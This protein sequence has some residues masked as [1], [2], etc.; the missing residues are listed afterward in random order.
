MADLV[1]KIRD[2]AF[3]AFGVAIG[4]A[5]NLGVPQQ[6]LVVLAFGL[7]GCAIIYF[8]IKDSDSGLQTLLLS[9]GAIAILTSKFLSAV[10]TLVFLIMGILLMAAMFVL[11]V[12]GIRRTATKR[13]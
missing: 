13:R 11:G 6:N 8:C 10:F 5:G 3:G 9:V 7:L 1:R 4:Y 12:K 2:L